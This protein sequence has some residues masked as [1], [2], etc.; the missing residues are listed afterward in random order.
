MTVMPGNTVSTAQAL[1]GRV[2]VHLQRIA[3][4]GEPITY[5]ALAEALELQPPNTIHQV[6]QALEWSMREDAAN[7]HPFIAA[8][9]ISRV[10]D[11]LPAPGFFDIAK[12][13]GRHD[14]EPSGPH[15]AASHG[16]MFAAA[17]DFWSAAG[18]TPRSGPHRETGLSPKDANPWA[19]F[20]CAELEAK[21]HELRKLI[22]SGML[23]DR[24][25]EHQL[26]EV[27]IIENELSRRDG[28]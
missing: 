25:M 10:R 22:D 13:L 1:A 27:G 17:V 7:G 15:A 5:K 26:T 9:V 8:L 21:L 6:A 3:V 19:K 11:G 12:E 4:R 28:G 24:S 16:A 2:R 23:T 20:T 14:G 18:L